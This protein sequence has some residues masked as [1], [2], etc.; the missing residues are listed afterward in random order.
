M[1]EENIPHW[2]QVTY[3]MQRKSIPRYESQED[4]ELPI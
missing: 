2:Q 1:Y 3:E 4:Q